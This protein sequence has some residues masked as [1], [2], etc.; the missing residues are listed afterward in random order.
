[1]Q[2]R[3]VGGE[4]GPQE[5]FERGTRVAAADR[6][7]VGIEHHDVPGTEVVAVPALRRVRRVRTERREL[8]V[9]VVEVA[10]GVGGAVL[11]VADS[12]QRTALRRPQLGS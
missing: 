7:A 11:V 6:G 5:L 9:E 8:A 2:S 10:G 1:M 3:G 4:V 12:G